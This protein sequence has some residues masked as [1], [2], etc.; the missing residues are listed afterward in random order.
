MHYQGYP[1]LPLQPL[2][3]QLFRESKCFCFPPRYAQVLQAVPSFSFF[4]E[5]FQKIGNKSLT[6]SK[7]GYPYEILSIIFIV[8]IGL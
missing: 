5:N 1:C 3:V 4:P 2:D 6:E 8:L 7:A